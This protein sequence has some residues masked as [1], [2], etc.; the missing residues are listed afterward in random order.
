[1][2]KRQILIPSAKGDEPIDIG[3]LRPRDWL[4]LLQGRVHPSWKRM[5]PTLQQGMQRTASTAA[6]LQQLLRA[7]LDMVSCDIAATIQADHRTGAE[8]RAVPRHK[9]LSNVSREP[10]RHARDT[11]THTLNVEILKLQNTFSEIRVLTYLIN[12][13]S[14]STRSTFSKPAI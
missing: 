1:M 7:S 14:D 3:V 9:D 10:R 13:D 11:I 12:I 2:L 4:G 8:P 6:V 5:I